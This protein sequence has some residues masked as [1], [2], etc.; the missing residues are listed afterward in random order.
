M[1][2]IANTPLFKLGIRFSAVFFA[3]AS[4]IKIILSIITTNF[5][6]YVKTPEFR[7]YMLM[8]AGF[9]LVYGFLMAKFKKKKHQK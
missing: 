1:S 4:F 2:K 7:N 3:V 5:S 9:S 6:E 8:L